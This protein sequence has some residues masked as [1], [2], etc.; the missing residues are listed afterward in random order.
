[1]N[2]IRND[3]ERVAYGLWAAGTSPQCYEH[4]VPQSN[5]EKDPVLQT[6]AE[7]PSVTPMVPVSRTEQELPPVTPMVPAAQIETEAPPPAPMVPV[8]P[9]KTTVPTPLPAVPLQ[10]ELLVSTSIDDAHKA[11]RPHDV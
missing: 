1:M 6:E 11:P 2:G 4:L 5:I 9:D 3:V 10:K 8:V 7:L